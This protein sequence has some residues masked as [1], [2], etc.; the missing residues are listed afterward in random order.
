M[1]HYYDL[2][3]KITD[4]ETKFKGSIKIAS[5]K[6]KRPENFK[7]MIEYAKKL[8]QHFPFV[9]VDLYEFNN[10]VF[11]SELTFT[12]SN[13]KAPFKDKKQRIYLGNLI[14]I[15]KISKESTFLN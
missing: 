13:A 11:L 3:W 5:I 1:Y 10:T 8:S 15:S 4:I 6:F 2:N 7:L 9:R 12:P 14:N